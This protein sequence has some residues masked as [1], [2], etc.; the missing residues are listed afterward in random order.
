MKKRSNLSLHRKVGMLISHRGSILLHA[1]RLLPRTANPKT[2][3]IKRGINYFKDL[4]EH[5]CP[6]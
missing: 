4:V 3:I 2:L 5:K 1:L 6:V